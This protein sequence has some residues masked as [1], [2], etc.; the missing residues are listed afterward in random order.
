MKVLAHARDR[1][2]HGPAYEPP[3]HGFRIFSILWASQSLSLI[4]NMLTLFATNVWLAQTMYPRPEQQSA[5]AFALATTSLAY[6]LPAIFGAPLA[7]ARVD[8]HD[9]KRIM[10][11]VES[12]MAVSACSGRR[13]WRRGRCASGYC[14]LRWPA[15]PARWVPLRGLR[16]FVRDAGS[17]T[18]APT[19]QR[20]DVDGT[21]PVVAARA[22]A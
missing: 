16:Q 8:R 14:C 10:L 18:A 13:C 22:R 6:G 1:N 5:L 9:R 15:L 17:R 19:G 11:F 4:G 2:R 3:A 7:G 21:E 20:Y 12:R